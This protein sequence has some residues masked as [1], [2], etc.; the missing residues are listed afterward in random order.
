MKKSLLLLSALFI[1]GLHLGQALADNKTLNLEVKGMSCAMCAAK[2]ESTIKKVEGVQKATVDN[3]TGKG[4]VEYADKAT[5]DKILEACNKTGFK[6]EL[7][8]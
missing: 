7:A 8:Q 6:C 3:K 4:T 5:P 1:S 2:V